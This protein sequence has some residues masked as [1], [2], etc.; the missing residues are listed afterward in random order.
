MVWEAV[1]RHPNTGPQAGPWELDAQG[2]C[3]PAVERQGTERDAS[4]T[5]RCALPSQHC[6]RKSHQESLLLTRVPEFPQS[7]VNLG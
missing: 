3:C 1:L 7:P 2:S 5:F 6:P 4:W